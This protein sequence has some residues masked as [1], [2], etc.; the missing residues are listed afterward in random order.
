[1]SKW[2][3]FNGEIIRIRRRRF[4]FLFFHVF[5]LSHFFLHSSFFFFFSLAT[6]VHVWGK[7]K[8]YIF[9]WCSGLVVFINDFK[10]FLKKYPVWSRL[11]LELLILNLLHY[12]LP[13]VGYTPKCYISCQNIN[14]FW[15]FFK[16]RLFK[17]DA[18]T[19]EDI[20]D[21]ALS[22]GKNIWNCI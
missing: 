4:C 2:L 3:S 18:V 21:V 15:I 5:I 12:S 13:H 16:S 10:N 17:E 9:T 7:M 22:M 11:Y 8:R 14:I 19:W 6:Y 1:M 20:N